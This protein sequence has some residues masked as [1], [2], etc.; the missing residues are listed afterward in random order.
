MGGKIGGI[1]LR[2]LVRKSKK[3]HDV[4]EPGDKAYY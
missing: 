1:L 3:G 2:A 4:I